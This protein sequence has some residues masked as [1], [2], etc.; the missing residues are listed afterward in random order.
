M[1][2]VKNYDVGSIR[3]DAPRTDFI[4][5]LPLLSFGD[6]QHTIGLSLVFN[7]RFA[8][9]NPF[10]IA[11]GY[12]LNMQKRLIMS[13]NGYPQSYEDEYG[14]V[15][16][17][18]EQ[19]DRYS[20]EDDTQRFIGLAG[21]DYRMDNPDYS[22]EIYDNRGKIK[23][24]TDKY[25]VTYLRYGYDAAGKLISITFR[26]NKVIE[27]GY[28]TTLGMI[29]S[30]SYKYNG[31]TVCTSAFT[32]PVSNNV[33]VAHYTGVDYHM[34]HYSGTYIAYS[35]DSGSDYSNAY[36]HKL[37]CTSSATGLTVQKEIGNKTVNTVGYDF[38]KLS[39][40]NKIVLMDA[41]DFHGVKT[42]MQFDGENL[43]YS[44]EFAE[45]MF[46]PDETTPNY[47]YLGKVNYHIKNQISGVQSYTDGV[48]MTYFVDEYST[49]FDRFRYYQ[50]ASG[51][52]MLSGWLKSIDNVSECNIMFYNG[53]TF[54]NSTPVNILTENSWMYFSVGIPNYSFNNMSVSIGIS[55]ERVLMADFKLIYNEN[56][57]HTTT[58]ETVFIFNSAE[59]YPIDDETEFYF[60]TEEEATAAMESGDYSS[61]NKLNLSNHYITANDII[62]YQ[63]NEIK[64]NYTNE[65]YIDNCKLIRINAKPLMVK[66]GNSIWDVT[67]VSVGK[68]YQRGDRTYLTRNDV[69]SGDILLTTVSYIDGT[70]ISRQKYNTSFDII[71]STTDGLVTI[72]QY[73]TDEYGRGT[74]LVTR[75][76]VSAMSTTAT[77]D[78][79]AFKLLST[80]DENDVTTTYTT[81][82][83]WG[84]VTKSTVSDGTS[85]T[86]TY[87]TDMCALEKKTFAKGADSKEHSFSYSGGNLTGL[88][89]GTLNYGFEYTNG[90]L[91]K[92]L[93]L[94]SD[95]EQHALSDSDKTLSSFYPSQSS[96]L[97][98][99]VSHT[100][101]YGRLTEVEGVVENTYD[102]NPTYESSQFKTTGVDNGAGK[103][104]TSTD[105]TNNNVTKYAYNKD[106]LQ[107][108]EVFNSSGTSLNNETFEYDSLGR[109][110]KNTYTFGTKTVG[111]SFSYLLDTTAHNADQRIGSASYLVNGVS[112]ATATNYF[113]IYKRIS[114]KLINIGNT[115]DREITYDATRIAR[116]LD[117]KNG[118]TINNVSYAYDL[119]GRITSES[120]SAN[121][122]VNTTYVYDSFGQLTRENNKAL[123]KTFVYSY[124]GIGNIANV[125]T[126][127]YTTGAVSGTPVTTSYTYDGTQ[128]DRLTSF[129]GK[130][131]TYDAN[132]CV[133]TYDGWTY[134]WTKGKLTKR[135]RGT[136]LLGIDTYTY[137][138][139]AY[140]RR[141]SKNYSFMKGT[142]VLA[143]YITSAST[144]YTY[145]A[146]GRLI[147][148]QYTE[149]F[150]DLSSNS[151]EIIYLYDE[152]GVIGVMYSYNGSTS[153][154]YFYRRNLQGDVTTIYNSSGSKV[155]EY[156]YDAWGNCTILSGASNDL[157]SNNPIR[158]RGYYLDSETGLYYLNARYYNPQWRRFIS[159]DSTDYLDPESVNGLNLYAYCY[160]DPVN[161]ADPSGHSATKWWECFLIV[162]TATIA[163]A[164]MV[165]SCVAASAAIAPFAFLYLGIAAN[166]TLAITTAVVAAVS[167]GISAF[168]IADVQSVVT[169]GK[170][171]YLSFLGNA[172][173]DIKGALYFTS[174]FLNYMGQY[175][176]PGW[177]RQTSGAKDALERGD[178]YGAYTKIRPEGN[179]T[180]IYDGNGYAITRYDF[181][182]SHGGMNP[183]IHY[184]SRWMHNNV[185][186]SNFPK[187]KV[188]P[189]PF[190]LP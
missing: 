170:D 46:T 120:D 126:Y 107:R 133:K 166:T 71:H 115:Y 180:T 161:Y 84:V 43:V 189:F 173:D 186:R 34:S 23:S 77:Y 139:D 137:T 185:L 7:S 110:T 145:D 85:V 125:K 178:P 39:S 58:E 78:L 94:N 75:K 60:C 122:N 45:S 29:E 142:Q 93:K 150:N 121:T 44:Y 27:I 127:A 95:I 119:H 143:V 140:G 32:Y 10:Y 100:D 87:D 16:T 68:R 30:I 147:R 22:Y 35:A 183:H 79:D 162:G 70:E 72:F 156:A 42:R 15:V 129:G 146:S 40:D 159:P 91:S 52:I 88:V 136:R 83:I 151:R 138:Y 38:L 113:D 4:Y 124:N 47:T 92:V 24:A 114:R 118:S 1:S 37:T 57:N 109:M 123:D 117:V 89:G 12:K 6:V 55:K 36:S 50:D 33:K 31:E 105:K 101:N 181:S 112:K 59:I 108:V 28:S 14:A 74:G 66:L 175:A 51:A 99:V 154:A 69:S 49:G 157:V 134:T 8:T 130:A 18:N 65:A 164:L 153:A 96:A 182:H 131:I 187:G 73:A 169:D 13:S 19:G 3:L 86:D 174:Y 21:I 5:E 90:S 106:K 26:E 103:L 63:I 160:N 104:A 184:F 67:A 41:T 82:P 168:V 2:Y 64:G 17:L 132:G 54:V 179:D 141:T 152:S 116:I 165:T 148:E 80:I 149:I 76:T 98:S 61:L 97:Y 155:G 81:D 135:V 171:N 172:Y 176:Q 102:V 144:T 177:G 20:F 163:I 111:N 53:G 190:S 128:V 62:K 158:Y 25:G 56:D 188:F 9:S 11:N 48:K 167:A